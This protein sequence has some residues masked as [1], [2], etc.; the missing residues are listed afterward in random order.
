MGHLQSEQNHQSD[1]LP[2]PSKSEQ[3]KLTGSAT[4]RCTG[5]LGT[6]K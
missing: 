6:K 5:H 4:E 1:R 3:V 2:R